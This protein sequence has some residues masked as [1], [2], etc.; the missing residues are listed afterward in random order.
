MALATHDT[1]DGIVYTGATSSTVGPFVLLGGKYLFFAGAA[2]TS[3]TLNMLLPDG[4]TYIAV[5]TST[6]FSTSAGSAPIDLPPGTYEIVVVSASAV[7]G[8]LV[9]IPYRP[10]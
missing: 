8:G 10:N 5:G 2:G 7:A 9:K 4:S 6:T 1:A 3:N